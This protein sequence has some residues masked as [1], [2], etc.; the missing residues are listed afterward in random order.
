MT[1]RSKPSLPLSALALGSL[2]FD[3]TPVAREK[4]CESGER[5]CIVDGLHHFMLLDQGQ[6]CDNPCWARIPIYISRG[7]TFSPQRIPAF[8]M[9]L[10]D[11]QTLTNSHYSPHALVDAVGIEQLPASFRPPH[12]DTLSSIAT[13]AMSELSSAIDQAEEMIATKQYD[14]AQEQ[15]GELL[16]IAPW[17]PRLHFNLGIIGFHSED[18]HLAKARFHRAAQLG[19]PDAL[20]AEWKMQSMLAKPL[21]ERYPEVFFQIQNG[22]R[23]RALTVLRAI[24]H[25][26]PLHGN[27]TLAYCLRSANCPEEG[28]EVCHAALAKDPD[29]SD[30]YGHLWTFHTQLNQDEQALSVAKERIWRYP[31]DP[32]AAVDA[33]DS[34]LLLN[35]LELAYCLTQLYLLHASNFNL[36]LKHL[37]KYAEQSH[38]WAEQRLQYEALFPHMRA[39]T[40]ETK[41][42]YAETLIE[43]KDFQSAFNTLEEALRSNPERV[44]TVLAYGRA[45]A[46]SGELDGAIRFISSVVNDHNRT[47]TPDQQ[48]LLMSLLSELLR[49]S[50]QLEEALHLWQQAPR[51]DATALHELGPRQFV[52]FACCLAES[53]DI[54]AAREMVD[55]LNPQYSHDPLVRQVDEALHELTYP[56]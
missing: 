43:L 12:D 30:V 29:Q 6:F 35:E 33:L 36:A 10:N 1:Q 16:R 13:A 37:F 2:L 51:L 53:G 25:E 5:F 41:V 48:L 15:F 44:E 23:L 31:M 20:N 18:Y 3:G 7:G 40:P 34:A 49:Y 26:H 55:L 28:I 14:V 27:A 9:Q 38:A 39:K 54:V 21:R 24:R 56:S 4:R 11:I 47:D 8:L 22:D 50:D 42:Q 32:Q 46:R 52:E 17:H 45:L 19:H